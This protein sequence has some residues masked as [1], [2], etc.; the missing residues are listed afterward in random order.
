MIMKTIVICFF[1]AYNAM[2]LAQAFVLPKL[3]YG[4]QEYAPNIDAT[5]MEIHLTKHHQAYINNLNK[6]I[7]GTGFE[8][9]TIEQILMT[10]KLGLTMRNNAGGHYNHSL[11]WEI[12]APASKQGR[13]EEGNVLLKK[14]NESFGNM[15]SLK[16][17][18]FKTAMSRFGSGWAWLIVTPNKSL[19]VIS[20]PNQDNPLM[21][22]SPIRGIPILGIDVWEHAY[23]LN[24]QN[25][26]ADYLTAVWGLL[27]WSIISKKYSAAFANEALLKQLSKVKRPKKH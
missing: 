6:E 26:R 8:Q 12:L 21:S 22:D 2:L 19:Q 20:S 11:F 13:M 10:P 24:Y 27:D 4:Y 3:P 25:R 5:T 16:K 14:I 15:D 1:L 7:K 17:E 9:K 23:Y 18:V